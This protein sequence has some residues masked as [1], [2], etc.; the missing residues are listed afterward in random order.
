MKFIFPFLIS[1]ERVIKSDIYRL[2]TKSKISIKQ[3]KSRSYAM[4]SL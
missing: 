3:D 4:L 1:K 2:I